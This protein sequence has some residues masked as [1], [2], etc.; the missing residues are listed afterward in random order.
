MDPIT[1]DEFTSGMDRIYD[2]MDAFKVE[3][4]DTRREQQEL[5]H[6]MNEYLR[7]QNGRLGKVESATAVLE[8]RTTSLKSKATP[9]IGAGAAVGVIVDFLVKLVK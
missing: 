9:W 4:R 1:R 5:L 2:Q 8:E 3:A 7:V 6:S